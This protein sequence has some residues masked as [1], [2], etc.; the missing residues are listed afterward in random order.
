MIRR[1]LPLAIVAAVVHVVSG[2]SRQ[3]TISGRG[4]TVSDPIHLSDG[5]L[6]LGAA[7]K[8]A[9]NF[10]VRVDGPTSDIPIN[11]IGDYRG[12]TLLPVKAGN[13]RFS[14]TAESDWVLMYEQPDPSAKPN[15][16]PISHAGEGD[17]PLGPFAFTGGPL[18]IKAEHLGAMN[19]VVKI[20]RSTGELIDIPINKIG[21]YSGSV[22]SRVRDAGSY[23]VSVHSDGKWSLS[24]QQDH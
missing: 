17:S 1:I 10:I 3:V 24:L 18:I 20:Y 21:A 2:Q 8:G 4:D 12:V 16:L 11:A 15:A 7:H 5:L 23:W 9:L 22:S 13:Y 19:F 6:M 14:V